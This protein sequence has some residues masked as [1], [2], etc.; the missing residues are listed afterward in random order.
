MIPSIER[1]VATSCYLRVRS[2]FSIGRR[3][4]RDA[5][6]AAE[7]L[8]RRRR[9]AVCRVRRADPGDRL[10]SSGDGERGASDEEGMV[11]GQEAKPTTLWW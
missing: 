11:A 5:E 1:Y 7:L 8:W 10:A 6:E 2:D 3:L 4:R 9:R